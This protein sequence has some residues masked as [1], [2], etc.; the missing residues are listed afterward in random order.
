MRSIGMWR[1]A[2][3]RIFRVTILPACVALAAAASPAAA[4]LNGELRYSRG[5]DLNPNPPL[6]GSPTTLILYGVYAT[7]CGVVDEASVQD[8]EHVRV[9][10][11]SLAVC[12]DS[13]SNM[14]V[15]TFALGAFTAGNHTVAIQLTMDRPDSGVTVY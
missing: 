11:R 7:P 12:P 9:R 6:A 15:A 14:W 8:P 4:Q 2:A 5:Y 3:A 10:V 13:S 1:R